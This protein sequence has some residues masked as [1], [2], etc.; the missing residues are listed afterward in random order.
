ME[1]NNLTNAT[2]AEASGYQFEKANQWL[3]NSGL[4]VKEHEMLNE[5]EV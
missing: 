4:W 5:K 2:T 3:P 1:Q